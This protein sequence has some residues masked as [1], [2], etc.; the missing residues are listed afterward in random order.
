MKQSFERHAVLSAVVA[1]LILMSVSQSY[2]QDVMPAEESFKP[3]KA[4]YSPYVGDYFPNRVFFGDTH[5]HTAMSTDAG[6]IGAIVR[7]EDAYRLSRVR[8]VA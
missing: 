3:P 5:L 7:P 8:V 2:G 6:M 1:V 4:E